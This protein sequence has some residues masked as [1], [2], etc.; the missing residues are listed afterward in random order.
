MSIPLIE[1][2]GVGLQVARPVLTRILHPLDLDVKAGSSTVV[3]GPSGAG[4]S[5]LASII[6]ALQMPSEG[7]YRFAG[8]QVVGRS[9]RALAAFR[10]LHLGFVFQNSHLIDERSAIANVELGLTDMR[11]PPHA[12]RE[13]AREVLTLVGLEE[14][15]D[16]RAANL[17]GGERHRVAIARALAKRPSVVIADEPTAALDQATGQAILDLLARVTDEGATLIVVTHD[18]R[19]T[20]MA[21]DV[22]SIIDGRR[23]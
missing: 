22:V 5:T 14:L 8:E 3:M 7:S 2:R 23:A 21:D 19:A 12:R 15:Q 10:S 13:R 16:R 9:R 18:T 1:L 20:A 17:S 11:T 4:K 6:G